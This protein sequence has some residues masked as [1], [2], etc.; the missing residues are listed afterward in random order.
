MS[1]PCHDPLSGVPG[2]I[3]TNTT[4]IYPV[5]TELSLIFPKPHPNDR[6][7]DLG[8]RR[9]VKP[10]RRDFSHDTVG[11]HINRELKLFRVDG[12]TACHSETSQCNPSSISIDCNWIAVQRLM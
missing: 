2:T 11:C 3:E 10:Q 1:V 6:A 8:F 7:S 4:E 9:S 12:I 5:V